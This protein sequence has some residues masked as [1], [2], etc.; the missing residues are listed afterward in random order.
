MISL[1]SI[2]TQ[3][4]GFVECAAFKVRELYGMPQGRSC[5]AAGTGKHV[6][7]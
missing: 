5:G 2:V 3:K 4:E 6:A 1:L 7:A